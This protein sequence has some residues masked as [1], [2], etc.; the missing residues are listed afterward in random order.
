MGWMKGLEPSASR[1]TIWRPNQ[2]GDIH[3]ISIPLPMTAA[4]WQRGTPGGTRTPDLLLRRQLLYPAELLAYVERVT[5]IEPARPAWKAGI[6]PLNYTRMGFAIISPKIVSYVKWCVKM[7]LQFFPAFPR[8][9]G[10]KS[11]ALAA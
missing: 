2:L 9:K 5:G 11:G 3:H 7:N 1:A 8:R 6:L 10:P 4:T